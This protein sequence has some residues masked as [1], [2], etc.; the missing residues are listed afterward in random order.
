MTKLRCIAI[1]DEPL[2]LQVIQSHVDQ[3]P[4]LELITTFPNPVEATTVL[5]TDAI[6]LIFLDIEMPLVSGIDFLKSLHNPPKVIFTT[7]Y[8]NY[9][10]ESYEL[11]VVDYLLKP[12]SF[13]RF[14]KAVNKCKHLMGSSASN[15][16]QEPQAVNDHIYVNANKKFVKIRFHDI[17]YVESVKDYVRIHTDDQRIMTKESLSQFES[18]LP[19]GFLRIHRS[20]IV[21]SAKVTAFTKVDVEINET[22]LPIG[23]SYKEGVIEVL[24]GN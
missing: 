4:D 16:S 2:A 19:N 22:E 11:D 8:R 15:H 14:F 18:K 6:D 20:F 5:Q 24:K 9:A 13:T 23:A 3:I 17:L 12:I 21:N 10:L 7:A 1:D